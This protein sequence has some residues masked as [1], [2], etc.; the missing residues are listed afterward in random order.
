MDKKI[1]SPM[2]SSETE[3]YTPPANYVIEP[4]CILT[5][6]DSGGGTGEGYDDGDYDD[7]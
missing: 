3:Q 6:Q 7:L 2:Q 5:G 1:T 4:V